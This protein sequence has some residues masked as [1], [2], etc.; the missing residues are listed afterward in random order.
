MALAWSRTTEHNG[1]H[2]FRICDRDPLGDP[3][4]IRDSIYMSPLE[5]RGLEYRERIGCKE[6]D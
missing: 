2:S 3:T 6:L 5:P 1:A 4:T